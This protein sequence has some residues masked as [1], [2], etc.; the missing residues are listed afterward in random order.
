VALDAAGILYIA[1]TI[2]R[3]IRRV[4][5]S[6]EFIY[7]I[8]G[9]GVSG[10]SSDGG[11]ALEAKITTPAAITIDRSGKVYFADDGNNRIQVLTPVAGQNPFEF[12]QRPRR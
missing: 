1:D 6:T 7:T 9:T 4:D 11:P 2:N 8:A 3:R 10:F 5:S 12:R